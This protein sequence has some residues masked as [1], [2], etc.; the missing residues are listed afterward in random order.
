M[1]QGDLELTLVRHGTTAWN[2][3]GRWQGWSDT[4]LGELGEAQAARLAR[5]LE[6]RTFDACWTSDLARARRTAE[7][8]LPGAEWRADPRL[9]ELHFGHYEGVTSAAVLEDPQY[10]QWQLDPWRRAAPGGGESVLAV[11]ERMAEWAGDLGGGR[12]LAVSHGAAIRALLCLLFDWP[13][14]PVPGY[15]LP[16]PYQLAYTALTVLRREGSATGERWTLITYNDHAHLEDAAALPA[17]TG[18]G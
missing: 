6:G 2:A 8:A 5:R 10:A 14:R 9:R 3:A 15:V 1:T 17:G 13:V 18:Q 11:A 4:P 12:V 7:L 16:F